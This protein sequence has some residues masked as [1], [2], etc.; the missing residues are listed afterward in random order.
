MDPIHKLAALFAQFPGIGSR[1]SRRFVYFL[2]KQQK[3]YV[4]ELA[5][6]IE[7]IEEAVTEC[8]RC[9]RYF[10]KKHDEGRNCSICIDQGRE[11]RLLMVL[12][13]DSDLDALER[14]GT[15]RGL[16]FVLGGTLPLLEKYPESKIRIKALRKLVEEEFASIKEIIFA[17]AVT[18]ESE[19][20]AAF[21]RDEIE[22]IANKNLMQISTLGRGLSTGTE[23]EYS[24]AE[25]LRYALE[26]RK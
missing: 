16:Y 13:K 2:L 3:S 6:L 26:G 14:S 11:R 25:T 1:Q 7:T 10:M 17:F 24:D 19:H 22:P 8:E 21:V 23:L 12:E 4:K 15:Y 18:P 5:S 20:T 9:H